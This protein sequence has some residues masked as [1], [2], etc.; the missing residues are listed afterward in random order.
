MIRTCR[1]LV[2]PALILLALPM[3]TAG[4]ALPPRD[5]LQ[6]GQEIL[7]RIGTDPTAAEDFAWFYQNAPLATRPRLLAL[8]GS[9]S[10]RELWPLLEAALTERDTALLSA[11]LTASCSL[12]FD[13][14]D[15][16]ALVRP[17]LRHEDLQVRN[18]ALTTL[19]AAD[20]EASLNEMILQLPGLQEPQ[21]GQVLACLR[22]LAGSD[23]GTD[24]E[25]WTAWWEK[26]QPCWSSASPPAPCCCAPA[27]GPN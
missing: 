18:G 8:V 14:V 12:G 24:P 6:R 9:H 11:A 27:T 1:P 22:R 13:S 5:P 15:Q 26:Q 3:L 17:L 16:L 10:A 20:D 7:A 21:L 25:P 23:L 4:E 2:L 19:A